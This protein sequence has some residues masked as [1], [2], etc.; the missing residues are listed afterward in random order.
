MCT[1]NYTKE[2]NAPLPLSKEE[3]RIILEYIKQ[4]DESAREYLIEHNMRLV[5]FE[6]TTRFKNYQYDK[7]ELI[8]IGNIG[9]VKAAQTYDPSK[10]IAFSTY[11][12]KCIDNEILMFI[13][14]QKKLF[15]EESLSYTIFIDGGYEEKK[16]ED[17]IRSDIDI[18]EEYNEKETY[19]I[20][21]GL[22][23]SLSERDRKI[24]ILYYGFN[25]SKTHTTRE[26]AKIMSLSQPVI[27]RIIH[28]NLKNISDK[29]QEL[30]VIELR[31]KT[32][33]QNNRKSK[34]K[35][36]NTT[37]DKKNEILKEDYIK[38]LEI[39]KSEDLSNI[40]N[41]YTEKE[42]IILLLKLGYINGKDF[43]SQS[44]AEFLNINKQEV[45]DTTKRIINEY[46]EKINSS[47]V[48]LK[49]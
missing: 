11:A 38:L 43:S 27:V 4:G 5:L 34:R 1:E 30:G 13:R 21:R 49:I 33:K 39:L 17:I 6:V 23:D 2:N 29:L 3:E 48:L 41:Y 35:K 44:V 10:K 14:K 25:N 37:K 12:A 42:I 47:E 26:I 19:E 15:S 20:I 40:L 9:L 18:E 46:K 8:A 28:R 16:L 24:M 7:E 31:E 45:I 22:I 32:K 36:V